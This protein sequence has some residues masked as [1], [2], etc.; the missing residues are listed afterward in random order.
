MDFLSLNNQDFILIRPRAVIPP[1]FF[2]FVAGCPCDSPDLW[3]WWNS[4]NSEILS[5]NNSRRGRF[6][7]EIQ[8]WPVR[9][10]KR[11]ATG[12]PENSWWG[13]NLLRKLLAA[14]LL[15]PCCSE[16]DSHPKT[17]ERILGWILMN[18]LPRI[19]WDAK[20]GRLDLSFPKRLIQHWSEYGIQSLNDSLSMT[21]RGEQKLVEDGKIR[22]VPSFWEKIFLF[23]HE[24]LPQIATSSSAIFVSWKCHAWHIFDISSVCLWE[25]PFAQR[26]SQRNKGKELLKK[27]SLRR[28]D[29]LLHL[30]N[31]IHLF[32]NHK[33]AESL[34]KTGISRMV[35]YQVVGCVLF[36]QLWDSS[37]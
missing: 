21:F 11:R 25:A 9:N 7:L 30:K 29:V 6:A 35:G 34:Q 33:D 24:K 28:C 8:D 14:K 5:R 13:W 32:K 22:D 23:T 16:W 26:L 18:H 1:H 2:C 27:P 10:K 4:L 15:I 3:T 17:S 12:V 37:F 20:V 36:F 19:S 31:E